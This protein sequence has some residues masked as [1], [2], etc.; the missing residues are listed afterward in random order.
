MA[1]R[2][3]ESVRQSAARDSVAILCGCRRILNA[4]CPDCAGWLKLL[5]PSMA[6]CA[7]KGWPALHAPAVQVPTA[8]LV[9]CARR[10][11]TG[12]SDVCGQL[13]W[14]KYVARSI[15]HNSVAHEPIE[16]GMTEDEAAVIRGMRDAHIDGDERA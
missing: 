10:W 16:E 12:W 8:A 13:V 4:T 14:R 3:A 1:E 9:S 6:V 7:E 11:A 5:P 2:N 15:G